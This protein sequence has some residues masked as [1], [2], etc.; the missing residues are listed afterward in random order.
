MHAEI[1]SFLGR[2]K[3]KIEAPGEED[4][5]VNLMGEILIPFMEIAKTQQEGFY[6]MFQAG[7][8]IEELE[9]AFDMFS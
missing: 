3:N 8:K 1:F 5:T 6:L 4:E 7:R 9:K 2:L